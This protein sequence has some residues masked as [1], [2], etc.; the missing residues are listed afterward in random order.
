[1]TTPAPWR[2]KNS[3]VYPPARRSFWT[4]IVALILG[5]YGAFHAEKHIAYSPLRQARGSA[6]LPAQPNNL[7]ERIVDL[8]E[9]KL[10]GT[11]VDRLILLQ[12]EQSR[13]ARYTLQAIAF[14][15]PGVLGLT[16]V[17]MGSSAM[18]AI[19]Q[20]RGRY[21]GNFYGVFAIMIG[22]LASIIS[23]CMIFSVYLW[24]RMP[25]LYTS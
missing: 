8:L 21:S 2:E 5:L 16:A 22:G 19:E 14:F 24:P 20:Q 6:G 17:W 12:T 7:Y 4:A 25:H 9:V 11:Q 10:F 15:L 13:I 3:P 1:M 18:T 23:A